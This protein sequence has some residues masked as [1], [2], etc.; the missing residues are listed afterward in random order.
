MTTYVLKIIHQ[1]TG[2]W[3]NRQLRSITVLSKK[4]ALTFSLKFFTLFT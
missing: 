4:E 1:Q 3:K 2:E